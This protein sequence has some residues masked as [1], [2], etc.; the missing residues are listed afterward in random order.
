MNSLEKHEEVGSNKLA[1]EAYPED[2]KYAKLIPR[3]DVL[4]AAWTVPVILAVTPSNIVLAGSCPGQGSPDGSGACYRPEEP[5][6][7]GN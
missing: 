1:T 7:P 4:K 6:Q 2:P 5:P 3:R